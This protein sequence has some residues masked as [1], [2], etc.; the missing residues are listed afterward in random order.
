MAALVEGRLS[1]QA[2]EPS[3]EAAE[4]LTYPPA[5][6]QKPTI[7]SNMPLPPSCCGQRE[8]HRAQRAICR[9][10][11]AHRHAR[12]GGRAER[13][14]GTHVVHRDHAQLCPIAQHC[15]HANARR[16]L[17]VPTVLPSAPCGCSP[18][19]ACAWSSWTPPWMPA[20]TAHWTTRCFPCPSRCTHPGTACGTLQ[21]TTP[22]A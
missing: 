13:G 9:L 22:C 17:S 19:R 16:S 3:P 2:L 12:G 10:C 4:G 1:L 6:T 15:P 11:N 20:S 14:R 5:R 8:L 7:V 21:T 18:G